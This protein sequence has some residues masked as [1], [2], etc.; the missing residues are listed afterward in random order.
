MRRFL[1]LPVLL[2][3]CGVGGG[4]NASPDGGRKDAA[5]DARVDAR[6]PD[7]TMLWFDA[8]LDARFAGD[9]SGSGRGTVSHLTYTGAA[10][11]RTY[12]LF[13]PTLAMATPRPLVVLLHACTQS[14]DQF[15]LTTEY[16]KLA[17]FDGFFVA[18]PEQDPA[19]N[20]FRC[21]RWNL[22]ANQQRDQGEPSLIAGI[23][24]EIQAAHAVDPRRVYVLGL[25]NGGALAV[26]MAATYPDLYAAAGSVGGC[27][28]QGTPCVGAAPSTAAETLGQLVHTAQ[29]TRARAVP[30]FVMQGDADTSIPAAN[31][32]EIV[33]QFLWAADLADGDPLGSVPKTRSST[34]ALTAAGGESYD[35]DH[36]VDR[37]GAPL[38]DRWLVHGLGGF[39]SGGP[40]AASFTDPMGPAASDA[41]WAFFS[42]HPLP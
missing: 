26:T 13:T 6:V 28:Y 30:L 27:A 40:A 21:W 23:T 10:G 39:W 14:A 24:Q 7:A 19:V 29:G 18:F 15:A 22:A 37:A 34:E 1:A 38:I 11:T 25:G 12:R 41:S 8:A 35:L 3:A 5:L 20:T 17:A 32:E 31:A 4:D 9:G 33:Q 42:A 16:E 36:Y 2:A